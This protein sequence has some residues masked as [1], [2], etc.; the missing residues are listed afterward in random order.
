ME[1]EVIIPLHNGEKWIS[2]TL[3]SVL[4][5]TLQPKRII[6]VDDASTDRSVDI[7]GEFSRVTVVRNPNPGN[8]SRARN[9][10]ISHSSSLFVAFLDQD[11]VWEATHLEKLAELL[12]VHP[13]A[14]VALARYKEFQDGEEPHFDMSNTSSHLIQGWDVYPFG[15]QME[16][17]L[18]LFRRQVFDKF[19]WVDDMQGCADRYLF[20]QILMHHPVIR[21]EARSVARRVHG[22]SYYQTMIKSHPTKHFRR[23]AHLS[24]RLWEYYKSHNDNHQEARRIEL[25]SRIMGTIADVIESILAKNNSALRLSAN[26]L[27]E[28]LRGDNSLTI[29]RTFDQLFVFMTHHN[30]GIR[31]VM[32]AREFCD[33]ICAKWPSGCPITERMVRT[34]T[35]ACRHGITFFFEHILRHPLQWRCY[36]FFFEAIRYRLQ[37]SQE[38][39]ARSRAQGNPQTSL[40]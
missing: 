21:S 15:G 1:I 14:M 40:G 34:K 33:F 11:D 31:S 37:Q 32:G 29:E 27:E 20:H 3:E 38:Y 28:I 6:V 2:A 19:E 12:E 7:A 26:A 23:L 30:K 16:P 18:I 36:N 4:A 24:E 10:G 25:R 5:Q 13:Q 17:S 35:M 8:P 39:R 22:E 9:F